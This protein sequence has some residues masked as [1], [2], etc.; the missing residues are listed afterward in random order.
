MFIVEKYLSYTKP[1][2]FRNVY[3]LFLLTLRV[4]MCNIIVND[5]FLRLVQEGYVLQIWPLFFLIFLKKFPLLDVIKKGNILPKLMLLA[6]RDQI[7]KIEY[8]LHLFP[9]GEKTQK[10]FFFPCITAIAEAIQLRQ[11][12]M[13]LSLKSFLLLQSLFFFLF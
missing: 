6:G 4:V 10:F 12:K 13:L 7:T 9:V 3:F 8:L 2:M 11:R 1:E 5:A